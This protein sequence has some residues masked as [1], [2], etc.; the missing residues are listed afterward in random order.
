MRWKG[1]LDV[2]EEN[3]ENVKTLG[4]WKGELPGRNVR[5]LDKVE[6]TFGFLK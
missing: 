3:V 5:L 2:F 1:W 4:E 6:Y